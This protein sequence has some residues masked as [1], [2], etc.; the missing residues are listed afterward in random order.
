MKIKILGSCLTLIFIL[1]GCNT[2][3]DQAYPEVDD[4]PNQ[5]NYRS[6][7]QQG[8]NNRMRK[9]LPVNPGREQ[10]IFTT[11]NQTI[12]N[13]KNSSN[14]TGVRIA[15]EDQQRTADNTNAA[16]VSDIQ[17]E[18]IALTNQQREQKGLQPL[19]EDNE[20]GRVAQIKAE[21]MASNNYFSHTSPTYGSPFEMLE[22]LGVSYSNAA[23][24]IASGQQSAEEVVRAWMNSPGHRENILSEKTTHI[25]V[26][27]TKQGDYWTQLFINK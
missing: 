16:S 24:N 14:N 17:S 27:Y 19:K 8:E 5:V 2:G 9:D 11:P 22:E 1:V 10:N 21:D 13:Q 3:Q 6:S 4:T 23:E 25:G 12:Y 7:E 18:V 26:G 20:L 15:P